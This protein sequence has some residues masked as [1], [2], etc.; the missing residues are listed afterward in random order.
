[1]QAQAFICPVRR[2]YRRQFSAAPQLIDKNHAT[3]TTT[4]HSKSMGLA[5]SFLRG[6]DATNV[7][8][9][10]PPQTTQQSKKSKQN[11][12]HTAW[13]QRCSAELKEQVLDNCYL[14]NSLRASV[15]EA[16]HAYYSATLEKTLMPGTHK[17][18]GGARD[19]T[20]GC[21]YG[22]PANAKALLCLYFDFEKQ[23]YQMIAIPLP[24]SIANVKMKWLR[25]IVVHG[26]LWAIPSWAPSVLCV[27]LDAYWGR[28]Q[29]TTASGDSSAPNAGDIVQLIDLPNDHPKGMQWQWHGAGM[30]HQQTALYCIPSNAQHVL[31][32]DMI[33]KTTSLIHIDVDRTK[34]PN[35]RLDMANKWYGGITGDDNCVYGIPYRSCAVLRIDCNR[36]T[37]TLMGPDYG[38]DKYNWHGG[39]LV[40]GKLYAHPSHAD[41]VLV[42]DTT[43]SNNNINDNVAAYNDDRCTELP[44]ER[45]T[46]DVDTRNNYKW[47]GGSIGV[48]GNIYCPAC[49]TSSILKIDTQTNKVTTF[50]FAGTDKNKWQG[51]I[52][53]RDGCVYCIPASG[54]QVLRISTAGD[55]AVQLI[56]DLPAYKD[57]WQGGHAGLDGS[58][59]FIPENGFRVLKVTP[60]K[61]PPLVIDG[62]LPEND[63][64][65]EYV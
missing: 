19:A 59:Y 35:M 64:V 8:E 50:G 47:L 11:D 60:P 52:L 38:I 40:R 57:K 53:G 45:A 17:H 37:A 15:V 10:S 20:D 22:V 65:I 63:V 32:V 2:T 46:Y 12:A 31:K 7:Q 49:D 27:D 4:S 30:N 3:T 58:L 28:R 36:D 56:G 18:L 44:I 48:D 55:N 9:Q 51:G 21:I 39:V 5:V 16:A 41:T 24:A 43:T 26:Y 54:R 14:P 13:K 62:Q 42:I 33:T 23:K 29:P 6:E 25:G 34:Y 61:E 1:L